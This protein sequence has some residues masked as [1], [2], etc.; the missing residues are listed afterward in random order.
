MTEKEWF[1]NGL[2]C[3]VLLNYYGAP[4]GYVEI[5]GWSALKYE[6]PSKLADMFDDAAYLGV[7][8][9]GSGLPNGECKNGCFYIGFDMMHGCDVR[10]EYDEN[11]YPQ[12][13]M[14]RTVEDC[15]EHV[16]TLADAVSVQVHD[17]YEKLDS[18]YGMEG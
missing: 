17:N 2:R 10:Y 4:C 9:T 12:I 1:H 11:D 15:V 13:V 8:Y 7:T 6:P 18:W 14:L 5:P 3:F 16:N